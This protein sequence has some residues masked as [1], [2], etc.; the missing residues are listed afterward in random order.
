MREQIQA[1]C[2]ATN[3]LGKC[4]EYIQ[5]D[6][7]NMEK[8]YRMWRGDSQSYSNKLDAQS[9]NTESSLVPLQQELADET[10]KVANLNAQINRVK[11]SILH[12]DMT[13]HNL[14]RG[15]VGHHAQ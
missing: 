8:E 7:E 14:L 10:E 12:N 15:V 2:Q 1:L 3:P 11:A 6:L 13:I 9:N 5:E 4:I